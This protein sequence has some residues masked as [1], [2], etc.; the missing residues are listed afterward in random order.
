MLMLKVLAAVY[1]AITAATGDGEAFIAPMEEA[2]CE[3]PLHLL[4]VNGR[5]LSDESEDGNERA[6]SN[7]FLMRTVNNR[8]AGEWSCPH[9]CT[10]SCGDPISVSGV[11]A[12]AKC[13]ACLAA[14]CT[15]EFTENCRKLGGWDCAKCL[16]K[17]S[18]CFTTQWAPCA[19][20]CISLWGSP[21]SDCSECWTKQYVTGCLDEY[22][23]CLPEAAQ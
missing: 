18:L 1:L 11:S 20:K 16:G 9:Q 8:T 15:E 19:G 7:I 4:Q 22:K 21:G 6:A 17:G 13:S 2:A 12:T 23:P 10:D 5:K 3:E 14:K